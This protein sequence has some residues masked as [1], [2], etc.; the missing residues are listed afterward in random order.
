FGAAVSL[1]VGFI[2]ARV[3]NWRAIVQSE[4][5]DDRIGLLR[6]ENAFRRRGP[7]GRLSLGLISDQAGDRLVPADHADVRLFGVGVLKTIGEPVRHR[8]TEHQHIAFGYGLALLRW[9]RFRKVF[10]S[11]RRLLLLLLERGEYI[12]AEPA[13]GS[14]AAARLGP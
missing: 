12:P 9:R 4:H 5:H 10:D 13:A 3:T 7:I 11:F 6:R 8:V 2:G 1:L 14:A